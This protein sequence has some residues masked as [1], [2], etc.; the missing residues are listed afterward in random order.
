[1]IHVISLE[2]SLDRRYDVEKNLEGYEYKFVTPELPH[3]GQ[4]SLTRTHIS[5]IKKMILENEDYII[6]AE[7]DLLPSDNFSN[8]LDRIVEANKMHADVLL[9][10]VCWSKGH[11]EI[12]ETM[13]Q[14]NGFDGTQLVVYFNRIKTKLHRMETNR[15]YCIS[16]VL[17]TSFL[18]IK[19]GFPFCA[20]Q[21]KFDDA[22]CQ[23]DYNFKY[24]ESDFL[25]SKIKI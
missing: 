8:Y 15:N 9:L 18:N 22:M 14:A 5:L 17:M 2:K 20:Y 12:T 11:A 13:Y 21:K 3:D 25:K 24:R 23:S 1:M 10:G 4:W 16:H 7:D 6:V 19:I